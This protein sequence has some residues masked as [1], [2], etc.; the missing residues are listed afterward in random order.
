MVGVLAK[1]LKTI[2]AYVV[3]LR[4][5]LSKYFIVIILAV[6]FIYSV[7]SMTFFVTWL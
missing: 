5:V 2:R 1:A 7:L 3:S 4:I 6:F